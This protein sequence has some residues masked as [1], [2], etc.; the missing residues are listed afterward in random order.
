MHKHLRPHIDLFRK[1]KFPLFPDVVFLDGMHKFVVAEKEEMS[2]LECCMHLLI[3][4]IRL[5]EV[6][7]FLDLI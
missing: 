3:S 5:R 6:S 2:Y 7:F 1:K 4:I